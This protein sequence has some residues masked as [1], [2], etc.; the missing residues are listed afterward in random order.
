MRHFIIDNEIS[1]VPSNYPD[2]ERLKFL[3]A[4][5]YKV[6]DAVH[7]LQKHCNWRVEN[8]PCK[9]TVNVIRL[10]VKNIFQINSQIEYRLSL[11]LWKG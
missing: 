6:K 11:S 2:R 8:L 1:D 3:Q 9:L 10:L 7:A 5:E 4:Y